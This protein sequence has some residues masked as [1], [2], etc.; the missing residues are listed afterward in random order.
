[1]KA[2][3]LGAL[4]AGLLLFAVLAAADNPPATSRATF[5]LVMGSVA[6]GW[7]SYKAVLKKRGQR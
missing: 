2:K 3:A 5:V 7:A 6:A 1:M 4:S